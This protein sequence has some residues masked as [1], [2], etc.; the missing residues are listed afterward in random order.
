MHRPRCS[1]SIEMWEDLTRGR[2]G[3]SRA[4]RKPMVK[5]AFE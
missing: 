4:H 3:I 5:L 1:Q 2:Y